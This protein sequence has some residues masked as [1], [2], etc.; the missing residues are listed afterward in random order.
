M[1]K[2]EGINRLDFLK[3]SCRKIEVC[4]REV[5]LNSG[6]YSIKFNLYRG[7]VSS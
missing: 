4:E 2:T 3:H 5:A 6:A 7:S 1:R